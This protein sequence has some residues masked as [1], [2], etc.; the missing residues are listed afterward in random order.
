MS[1]LS[2]RMYLRP[3]LTVSPLSSTGDVFIRGEG[4]VYGEPRIA[5][6]G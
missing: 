2:I 1:L 4:S 5:F 6:Q 3:N